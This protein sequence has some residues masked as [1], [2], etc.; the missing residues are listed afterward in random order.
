[1]IAKNTT[2]LHFAVER[3]NKEIAENIITNG[4]NVNAKDIIEWT[5]LHYAVQTDQKEI[6]ELLIAKG[7]DVNAKNNNGRTPLDMVF[8]KTKI[9]LT[10]RRR[11]EI[12]ELLGKHGGKTKKELEAAGN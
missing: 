6:I 5:P 7:A 4:A 3:C 9:S 8:I 12:A 2:S 1:M 10:K 11:S